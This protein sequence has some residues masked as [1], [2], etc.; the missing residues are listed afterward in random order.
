MMEWKRA[1][2]ILLKEFWIPSKY[3]REVLREVLNDLKESPGSLAVLEELTL[4]H[5]N[6]RPI[7]QAHGSG[8]HGH[9][10]GDGS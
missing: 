8:G 4:E 5:L 7:E 10:E 3:P 6:L 2:L 9:G 1:T